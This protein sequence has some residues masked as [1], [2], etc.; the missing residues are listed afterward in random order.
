MALL[1]HWWVGQRKEHL[2]QHH[3]DKPQSLHL[4]CALEDGRVS[5]MGQRGSKQKRMKKRR[6][7]SQGAASTENMAASNCSK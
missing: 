1:P 2:V 6:N 4:L 7:E 5:W 3:R